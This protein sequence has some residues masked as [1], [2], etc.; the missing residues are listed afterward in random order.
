M[1]F[2]FMVI[3]DHFSLAK[4]NV[5]KGMHGYNKKL[6]F[7]IIIYCDTKSTIDM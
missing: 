1:G 7:F 2:N 4:K 3:A 5:N 6:E